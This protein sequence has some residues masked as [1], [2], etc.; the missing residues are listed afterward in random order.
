MNERSCVYVYMYSVDAYCIDREIQ[1]FSDN[2]LCVQPSATEVPHE[3]PYY[4]ESIVH[5]N[6][7]L[8][9]CLVQIHAMKYCILNLWRACG[10]ISLT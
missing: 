2:S 8:H 4:K 7:F 6:T 5:M 3:Q 9:Y 1:I 10:P